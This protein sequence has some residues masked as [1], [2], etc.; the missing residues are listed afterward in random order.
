MLCDCLDVFNHA[1]ITMWHHCN[2]DNMPIRLLHAHTMTKYVGKIFLW[3]N[4]SDC[5]ENC[6]K[7]GIILF[8]TPCM[9]KVI[10]YAPQMAII[11]LTQHTFYSSRNGNRKIG[12]RIYKKK[13]QQI[14]E[15]NIWIFR[16]SYYN[17]RVSWYSALAT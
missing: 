4:P 11:I 13:Q 9:S 6:K 10:F 7:I 12:F 16:S 2:A 15:L 17:N 5:W 1:K 8:A 3:K 14:W